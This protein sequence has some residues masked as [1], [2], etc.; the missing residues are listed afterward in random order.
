MCTAEQRVSLTITGPVPSFFL[1]FASFVFSFCLYF[2]SLS[3]LQTA[4]QKKSLPWRPRRPRRPRRPS[5]YGRAHTPA[6]SPPHT[7]IVKTLHF[8]SYDILIQWKSGIA[9]MNHSCDVYNEKSVLY[10][11]SISYIVCIILNL[12]FTFLNCDISDNML[13]GIFWRGNRKEISCWKT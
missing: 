1:Y 13:C 2:F 8:F 3:A 10:I 5:P 7:I 6:H 12:G 4:W 11:L 9:V